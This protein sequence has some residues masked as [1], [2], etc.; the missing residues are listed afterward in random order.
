V[1]PKTGYLNVLEKGSGNS[2]Y[3]Y[4]MLSHSITPLPQKTIVVKLASGKYVKL[5]IQS[6][7]KDGKG[8]NGYYTFRYEAIK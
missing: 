6:Y 3:E 5:E 1:A 2:W 7:Y 4:D 8:D